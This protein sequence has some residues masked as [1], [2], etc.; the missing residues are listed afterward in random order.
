[1]G[2][3][4]LSTL[5]ITY[6]GEPI[7]TEP[8]P[9]GIRLSVENVTNKGCTL[10]CTHEGIPWDQLVTGSPWMLEKWEN[11]SWVS[12]MPEYTVWT[13]IAYMVNQNDITRWD[14]NWNLIVGDLGPGQYR[15]GKHF[16]ATRMPPFTIGGGVQNR[17]HTYWAEFEIA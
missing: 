13:S 4:I 1:M 8:D 3:A 6:K 16:S 11:G 5:Q 10:V 17:E 14:I 7:L 12:V 15:V 2:L 9:L